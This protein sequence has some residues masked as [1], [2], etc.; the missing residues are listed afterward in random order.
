MNL[1]YNSIEFLKSSHDSCKRF[2]I[3]GK[4]VL[5]AFAETFFEVLFLSRMMFLF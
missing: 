1:L 2:S 4:E 5:T 3:D